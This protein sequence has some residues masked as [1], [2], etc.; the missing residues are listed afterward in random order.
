MLTPARALRRAAEAEALPSVPELEQIERIGFRLRRGELCMIAGQ[1]GSMKST[2]ALWWA[3]K[4]NVPTLYFCA[5]NDPY[6]SMTRLL[7]I[8]TGLTVEDISLS[9]TD[10]D[11]R[12]YYRDVVHGSR[13]QF[14]FDSSPTLDDMA[15]EI[16]AYVELWDA[17][18]DLIIVDNLMNV[19]AE[20]GEEFAGL[21]LVAKEMHRM[22]R[23]TSASV[24]VLHHMREE[25]DPDRV[26]SRRMLSGKIA[27]LPERIMGVAFDGSSTFKM[28]VLKLRDGKQDPS[29]N[30]CYV[31]TVD[32]QRSTFTRHIPASLI[33]GGSYARES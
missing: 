21:R 2:F 23:E 19:E 9:I 29:G 7:A 6:V 32:P 31:L 17:Y 12:D 4:M 24:M 26:S 5:D 20:H 28:S 1:P 13:I 14:C 8:L 25:Q 15:D 18:P 33:Y 10:S 22:A 30:E 16:Q 27:Q 11:M 3:V